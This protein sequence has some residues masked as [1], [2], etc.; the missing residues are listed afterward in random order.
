MVKLFKIKTSA[1]IDII[2]PIQDFMIMLYI[3]IT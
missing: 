2:K 3:Y 1:S